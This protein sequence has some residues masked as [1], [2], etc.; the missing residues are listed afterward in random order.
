M[1]FDDVFMCHFVSHY[2]LHSPNVA[3]CL[4]NL[5]SMKIT[6]RHLWVEISIL[7]H[8]LLLTNVCTHISIINVNGFLRRMPLVELLTSVNPM[9]PTLKNESQGEF[10]N[11]WLQ[12]EVFILWLDGKK[13]YQDCNPRWGL[14]T[15][16]QFFVNTSLEKKQSWT[17][18]LKLLSSIQLDMLNHNLDIFKPTSRNNNKPTLVD[19][20]TFKIATKHVLLHV[21]DANNIHMCSF[22]F[23]WVKY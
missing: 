7:C 9:N 18:Q 22:F 4:L 16:I 23:A 1:D 13:E 19:N 2:N 5:D 12:M 15:C 3:S 20:I 8:H 6:L 21:G 10:S 11:C 14:G 17:Q